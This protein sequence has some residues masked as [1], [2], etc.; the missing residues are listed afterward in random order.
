MPAGILVPVQEGH[1]CLLIVQVRALLD[2]HRLYNYKIQYKMKAIIM[3]ANI[4][5]IETVLC[6]LLNKR[7]K[8]EITNYV[9]AG[10][11]FHFLAPFRNIEFHLP[12]DVE[13]HHVAP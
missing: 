3:L 2:N 13:M 12:Q 4:A 7:P 8:P 1:N 9:E 10:Q 11:L 6:F 5:S